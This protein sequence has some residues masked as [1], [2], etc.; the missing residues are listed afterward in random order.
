MMRT[1][2]LHAS[3][4]G[5]VRVL[6]A[7]QEQE[8]SASASQPA[9]NAPLPPVV[10]G[11]V[12]CM[13]VALALGVGQLLLG[14]GSV[15]SAVMRA[16]LRSFAT[17]NESF[18]SATGEVA[19]VAAFLSG[20]LSFTGWFFQTRRSALVRDLG[21]ARLPRA[22]AAAVVALA[23]AQT[24]VVASIMWLERLLR[25][26]DERTLFSWSDNAAS[27][28]LFTLLNTLLLAPLREE[29][30]F[31]GIVFLLV[32]NRMGTASVQRSAVLA[33][34]L[35]ALVHLVNARSVSATYSRSYVAYQMSFAALVG[36]FLSLR[37]AVSQ[38]LLECVLLH[39]VN[40]SFALL[41]DTQASVDLTDSLTLA[42][43][44][45]ASAGA[46]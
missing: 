27:T 35:F 3:S 4:S 31:R 24:L 38:S 13:E 15:V 21:L 46:V 42:A 33:S 8:P 10:A 22:S 44:A 37:F 7:L 12:L 36:V 18:A 25:G 20:A 45:S 2:W 26:A 40:N 1:R 5:L 17:S 6:V 19:S 11:V 9:L 30:F 28:S 23:A 43:G 39:A 41:V 32:W 14:V 16:V 29:L 34:A